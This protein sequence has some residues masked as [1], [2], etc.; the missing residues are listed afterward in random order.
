MSLVYTAPMPPTT[1]EIARR[2]EKDPDTTVV[3]TEYA[4][5]PTYQ[6]PPGATALKVLHAMIDHAGAAIDDHTTWHEMSLRNVIDTAQLRHLS[7]EEADEHLGEL[8]ALQLSYWV[9]DVQ[10]RSTIVSR[11]VV[12]ERAEIHIPEDRANQAVVVRWRFGS[13]FTEIARSSHFWTLLQNNVIWTLRSRYAIALFHHISACSGQRIR[14]VQLTIPELRDVLGVIPKRLS[15]FKDLNS[16]ALKPAIDQI[17]ACEYGRW[18]LSVEVSKRNRKVHTVDISWAPRKPDPQGELPLNGA[19]DATTAETHAAPAFPANGQITDTA[20]EQTARVHA[21]GH[22]PDR[23]GRDF[24]RWIQNKGTKLDAPAIT[25]SFETFA[26]GYDA[27]QRRQ[28]PPQTGWDG[29]DEQERS[30]YS[31]FPADG[32]IRNTSFEKLAAAHAPGADPNAVGEAFAQRLRTTG[33]P[34]ATP[35]SVSHEDDFVDF[36]K[37]WQPTAGSAGITA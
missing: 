9:F 7:A 4:R 17:N 8:N 18:T 37:D 33:V 25:A 24:A 16:R 11:G 34:F 29:R 5:A 21:P 6:N 23:I 27:V 30:A 3:P 14:T 15:T 22:A 32:K 2:R 20:W 12:V 1:L 31:D 13:I 19:A 35:H 26:K 36:C 28:Q 10:R